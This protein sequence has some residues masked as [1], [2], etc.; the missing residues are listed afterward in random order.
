MTTHEIELKTLMLASLDG[1]AASHRT[2]LDQLSRHLRAF[3]KRHL[4]RIGRGPEE[5]EDLVQEA[6]LAIHLKRHT[7]DVE[8]LLTPWVHAIARYKLIDYLRRNRAS[9]ANL[10]IGDHNELAAADDQIA[11][12]STHD[13]GQ[14]LNRLPTK[15]RH[16]IES[17]KLEGRSVAETAVRYD[18]T[19]SG[20]KVSIHRGIKAL[21]KLIG[22]ETR[23]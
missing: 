15:V 8:T 18:M 12:E 2:L 13:I 3:Y 23:A 4:A 22:R 14:L 17:V 20:V 1:D 6:L 5:A 16:A 7:F 19:E 21:A 11:V 10:P 9:Q